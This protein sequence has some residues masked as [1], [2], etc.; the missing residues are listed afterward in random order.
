MALAAAAKEVQFIHMETG[1]RCTR[2]GI[3]SLRDMSGYDRSV[4]VSKY[5]MGRSRTGTGTFLCRTPIVRKIRQRKSQD[6][7]VICDMRC[8]M[9]HM[10]YAIDVP[11]GRAHFLRR[12]NQTW[13]R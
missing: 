6:R 4:V 9:C 10:P 13:S 8:A 3:V 7:D 12:S 1:N 5:Q 2:T 11:F